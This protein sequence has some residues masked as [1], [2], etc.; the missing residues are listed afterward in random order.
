MQSY[1]KMAVSIA[2]SNG[3]FIVLD[4][5]GLFL[6]G[7][8]ASIIKGYRRAVVTPNVVEFKRLSEQLGVD[9]KTPSDQR[10]QLVSRKLGGVTVL[11]KGPKDI[12]ATD[13]TGEEADLEAS[14]LKGADAEFEKAKE[15]VEVDLEGGLKRCG[16]QGDVLSGAVGTFMAW[17]KCYED[18][19]FGDKKIPASRIPFLAAIGGSMVTRNTS[20]IA[21][22][23][24]GRSVVTEDMIS[25]IGKAFNEVFEDGKAEG[26]L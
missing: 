8:D 19:A 3:M 26:K 13:S 1:A 21:F 10:A 16:G 11:Q 5:D 24:H 7:Q 15:V 2:R 12:I 4:A 17:G 6:V 18:G 22:G 20:R 14:Q 25:E 9:P 23:K